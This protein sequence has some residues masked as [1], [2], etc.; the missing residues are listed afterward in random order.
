MKTTIMFVAFYLLGVG[1]HAQTT[2]QNNETFALFVKGHGYIK[3]QE[4]DRGINLGWTNTPVYEWKFTGG[5]QGSPVPV[6]LPVALFNL[7]ANDYVI[8][9]ERDNGINL[10][11]L[12]DTK[13]ANTRDWLLEGNIAGMQPCIYL[14]NATQKAKNERSYIAYGERDNG[15]NLVWANRSALCNIQFFRS[16]VIT[17]VDNRTI[18]PLATAEDNKLFAQALKQMDVIG[19]DFYGEQ[20]IGMAA[21][22]RSDIISTH[23]DTWFPIDGF[24]RTVCGT[25]TNYF[26]Y[27]GSVFSDNDDDLNLNIVPSVD[28]RPLLGQATTVGNRRAGKNV[29]YGHIQA[30]IDVLDAPYK[31]FFYPNKPD[32]PKLNTNVCAFG[33]FVSD[34]GHD[35]KPEIHTTEQIWWKDGNNYLL[36]FMCDVSGRFDGLLDANDPKITNLNNTGD[37]YDTDDGKHTFGGPWSP[38]PIKGSYAIAFNVIKGEEL[39]RFDI[40][41]VAGKN[42]EPVSVQNANTH[43]LVYQGDTIAVVTES[44]NLDMNIKFEKVVRVP[45]FTRVLAPSIRGYIILQMNTGKAFTGYVNGKRNDDGGQLLVKVAKSVI[46]KKPPVISVIR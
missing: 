37:D 4:R 18:L 46:K 17:Q 14:R 1:V 40:R 11:W 43:Y 25:M 15:I 26:A 32:A 5:V 39:V 12:K 3:Y 44:D 29:F 21:A 34:A 42:Y 30:E 13:L 23:T 16:P 28:F 45:A 22:E 10:R 31:D 27:D 7:T 36:S 41:K 24:K 38:R 20:F 35:H 33:P 2:I 6:A 8:Y 19:N 9:A